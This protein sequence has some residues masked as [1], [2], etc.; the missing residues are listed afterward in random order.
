MHVLVY[1]SDCRVL[2]NKYNHFKT[3]H[4]GKSNNT[5][6]DSQLRFCGDALVAYSS[7]Q[8]RQCKKSVSRL[9]HKHSLRTAQFVLVP[10]GLEASLIISGHQHWSGGGK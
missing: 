10:A 5:T 6:S 9:G 4:S 1:F 8:T 2:H 3:T 7:V